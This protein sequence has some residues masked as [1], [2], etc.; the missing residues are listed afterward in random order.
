[1]ADLQA[2]SL[3]DLKARIER[4]E[5]RPALAGGVMLGNDPFDLLGA[6][7]G[8]LHEICADDRRDGGVALGFA[9]GQA[10]HLLTPVRPALLIV[11]LVGETR[12]LGVPYGAGLLSFGIDPD[13]VVLGRIETMGEF[14]WAIE[15]ALGCRAV[16]AVIADLG[17]PRRELDFTASRRLSLRAG[18]AGAS[19]F[20]M[21]YGTGREASAAKLRWRVVPE[22]SGDVPFD[23]RAPGS[24]RLRAILEK[25]RL[26]GRPGIGLELLL[27]WT[28]NGFVVVGG[29]AVR[30]APA[31]AIAPAHGALP[32]ALGDRL[33]QA[34]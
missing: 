28:G 22:P 12:D 4:L 5:N 18:T 32:A 16:A 15:E 1:M 31:G 30:Q 23:A 9:L 3:A 17:R 24:P 27:D 26:N 20:L 13:A 14:L 19:L 34:G 7:P 8:L 33:S 21:R 10:R 11:Q 6:P 25:G 29:G 2:L